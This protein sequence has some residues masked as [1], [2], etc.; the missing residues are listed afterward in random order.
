MIITALMLLDGQLERAALGQLVE[1]RLLGF[2]RFRQRAVDPAGPLKRPEW[3]DD[4]GFDLAHHIEV[5]ERGEHPL[6]L[7]A[8]ADV[9]S[10]VMSSPLDRTRPLWRLSLVPG[11][12]LDDGRPATALVARIHHA[13]ADGVALVHVLM[14]LTDEGSDIELPEIGVARGAPASAGDLW[15]RISHDARALLRMLVLLPDE[16]TMLKTPLTGRKRAAFSAP[17]SLDTIKEV[18]RATSTKV[19]DV[20]TA[21]IAGALRTAMGYASHWLEGPVR[22]LVPVYV[23]GHEG[24][25]NHF[26]LVYADLP[27]AAEE[28]LER[29]S[30]ARRAMQEAKESPDAHVAVGVLGALGA[31][32]PL[33]QIGIELFTSKA[34]ML[35][36]NVPGPPMSVHL[37]GH[38]LVAPVVWAPVSGSLG[39]GFS[40]L[41]Y[42]GSLRLG[43]ATDESVPVAPSALVRAFEQ[44]LDALAAES[45]RRAG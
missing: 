2:D 39:L 24:M 4:P 10:D 27:V 18:A 25:G 8:L 43:V 33:E 41:S 16:R 26:G 31:S 19:N 20:L 35:I 12:V 15:R 11:V 1:R 7:A 40:L 38:E 30:L 6:T 13:V 45:A 34:S 5:V 9:V 14:R 44:E 36:T 22:A 28:P 3:S 37:A 17:V 29:L 21:A 23:R 42:A 32:Q